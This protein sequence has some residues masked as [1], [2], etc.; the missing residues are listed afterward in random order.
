VV[1]WSLES[2]EIASETN[3]R[4]ERATTILPKYVK[5]CM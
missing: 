2:P 4:L 5:L 1:S 3:I